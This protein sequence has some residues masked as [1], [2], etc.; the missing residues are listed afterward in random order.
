MFHQQIT[1]VGIHFPVIIVS[2]HDNN[3]AALIVET[4]QQFRLAILHLASNSSWGMLNS[5]TLSTIR[6]QR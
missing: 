1:A 3:T 6:S 5:L 4:I 2:G